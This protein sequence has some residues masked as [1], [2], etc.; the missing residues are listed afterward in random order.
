MLR[1]G[2]RRCD[3]DHCAYVRNF[4]DGSVILLILYV[5][6][7]LIACRDMSKVKELKEQL[8]REFGIKD[9]GAAQKILGMEI[10]RD[11]KVGKL[12]LSQ[13][14]YISHI[15]EKL[16]MSSAKPVSTLLAPH[17]ALSAKQCPSFLD[18]CAEMSTAPYACAVG[19]LMYATV[20]MRPDLA[21]AVGMVSKYMS[22][23]GKE[24]WKAVK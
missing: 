22:N 24:H 17:F 13:K 15:L 23:L 10:Q 12:W 7:M 8:G 1:I 6:D 2:Y 14:K 11:R 9:L 21:L 20:C 19:C 16:N 4:D 5:D 3:G 18:E